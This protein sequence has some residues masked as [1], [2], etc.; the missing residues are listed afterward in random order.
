MSNINWFSLF[1]PMFTINIPTLIVCIV[2]CVVIFTKWKQNPSGSLWAV[3]GFGLALVLCFLMPLVQAAVQSWVMQDEE[4]TRRLPFLT[5]LAILWSPI[6]AGGQQIKSCPSR[7][8]LR[9][10]FGLLP[11]TALK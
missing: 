7:F 11:I 6:R 3:L 10:F 1:L 4:V 8:F 5:G 2:A 9:F